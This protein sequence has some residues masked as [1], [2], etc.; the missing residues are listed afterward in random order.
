MND[1]QKNMERTFRNWIIPH[2]IREMGKPNWWQR[3]KAKLTN[4][5][6]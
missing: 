4:L 2:L 6:K 1:L 5:L 3:L